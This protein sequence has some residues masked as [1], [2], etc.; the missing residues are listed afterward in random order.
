MPILGKTKDGFVGYA[1]GAFIDFVNQTMGDMTPTKLTESEL[2]DPDR[3]SED[4]IRVDTA[5][6]SQH[7]EQMESRGLKRLDSD[8]RYLNCEESETAH[9]NVTNQPL[10][11]CL[12]QDLLKVMKTWRKVGQYMWHDQRSLEGDPSVKS[13]RRWRIK[14]APGNS[15]TSAVERLSESS[16]NQ[17]ADLMIIWMIPLDVDDSSTNW[18]RMMGCHAT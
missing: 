7:L 8:I 1:N 17:L 3:M 11:H 13:C 16:S 6:V 12:P 14:Y 5:D 4:L 18:H 15:V 2:T 10:D 9:D